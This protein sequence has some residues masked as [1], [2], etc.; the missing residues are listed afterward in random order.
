[1]E[2]QKDKFSL[3]ED[4][5]Y[6][7]VAYMAPLL[8]GVEDA[9]IAALKKKA[10]PTKMGMQ[11][12]FGDVQDLKKRF[13][14][15]VNGTTKQVAVI[16]SVSYGMAN[17]ALNL[18]YKEG[19]HIIMLEEQF[20]SNYY[21]WEA[22]AKLHGQEIKMI[23]PDSNS[24]HRAL[25]WN[26][27]ILNAINEKTTAVCC[28]HVHWADGTLYDL[29]A[30]S[31]KCKEHQAYLI[32]DGTQS[33]GALPFDLER[34]PVDVLVV[35]GYKWLLGHYG[36]GLAY[37]SE[38]FNSGEPIEH[39]WINK[40]D[41]DNFQALVDY[42]EEY[43]EGAAKYSMGEQSNFVLVS[44]L[45]KGIDQLMEWG[46]E[47]IQAYC[48]DLHQLL[49]DELE[50]SGFRVQGM[51]DSSSH[52]TAIRLSADMDMELIKKVLLENKIYVSYR[53]DAMRVSLHVFNSE[54]EIR[55]F[56]NILK[57]AFAKV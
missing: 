38:K 3:P 37:Y 39:N 12:F 6:L 53:G 23:G 32:I 13:A 1:M 47:N 48:R 26:Q 52:L 33:V 28:G 27:N 35:G 50:G 25:S 17:A 46:V 18:K 4:L 5:C 9:G 55:K 34:I 24:S 20:P 11:D 16:P 7:N 49:I 21:P 42:K 43:K 45:R 2:N 36:L 14:D 40:K 51:Q 8:K 22:A 19:G 41:S 54:A 31:R 15:L 44:M 29:E 30:I 57:N 56:A 10:D